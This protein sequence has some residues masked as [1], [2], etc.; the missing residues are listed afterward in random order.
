MP[1]RRRTP[2]VVCLPQTQRAAFGFPK[3]WKSG[4]SANQNLAIKMEEHLGFSRQP[5]LTPPYIGDCDV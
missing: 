1:G 5:R 2:K 4:I 3:L